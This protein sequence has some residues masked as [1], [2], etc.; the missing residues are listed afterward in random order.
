MGQASY[1]CRDAGSVS[2]IAFQWGAVFYCFWERFRFCWN[3]SKDPTLFLW[4]LHCRQRA[5]NDRWGFILEAQPNH[6]G[7]LPW[8]LGLNISSFSH[9]SFSSSPQRL[10]SCLVVIALLCCLFAFP[11]CQHNYSGWRFTPQIRI[12]YFM[13]HRWKTDRPSDK[14]KH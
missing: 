2:P 7:A 14:E 1:S 10:Q 6:R 9:P 11:C 13:L 12:M 5:V 3:Q 8:G 4:A